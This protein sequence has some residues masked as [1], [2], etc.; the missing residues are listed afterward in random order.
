MY[1][2]K[3][4]RGVSFNLPRFRMGTPVGLGMTP[5]PTFVQHNSIKPKHDNDS[6]L[7]FFTSV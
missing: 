4:G 1:S 6:S 5:S 7:Y 2:D 3:K